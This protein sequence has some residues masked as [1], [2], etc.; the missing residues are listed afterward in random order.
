MQAKSGGGICDHCGNGQKNAPENA[1]SGRISRS[2][3]T[4]SAREIIV[5][6]LLRL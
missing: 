5:S 6:A 2:M 1:I 4:G 3:S